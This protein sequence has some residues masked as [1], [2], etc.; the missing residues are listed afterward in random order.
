MA[1]GVELGA[2]EE[3]EDARLHALR[4]H[5]LESLSLFVHLVQAVAEHLDEE[6]L[7]QSVVPHQLERHLSPLPGQ[8]LT[9]MAV[10][11]DQALG[12]EAGDHLAHRRR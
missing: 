8:L 5:V 4:D 12:R 1:V 11:L 3:L 7:Q 9:A 6:H 10:V 2:P